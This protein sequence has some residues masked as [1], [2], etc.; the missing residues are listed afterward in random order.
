MR[1]LFKKI[2][3]TLDGLLHGVEQGDIGL[4]DIQRPFVWSPTRVRDLFDSMFKGFPVG[5]LL[6][7]AN[8][9][10]VGT[11][12]IGADG[13]QRKVPR[14]LIVDGQQRL[15]SL[16]AV[17]RGKVVLNSDFEEQRITL[18]FRPRDGKFEVA[19][20]AVTRDPEF[21]A[22]LSSIW[23]TEGG[24]YKVITDFLA[25]LA[26]TRAHSDEEKSEIAENINRA[27]ALGA[28]PFTALEI[29]SS[30]SEEQVAD[31]FVRIN[32]EG[33]KLNE[34][35]FILTLLSVFWDQGRFDLEWFART[36]KK[37]STG[38]SP[39]NHHI[40]PDPDQLLRTA[41][42]VGFGRGRLNSVYQV[43]RGKNADTGLFSEA[44]RDRQF[45]RLQ[46]AQSAVLDL[47]NWHEFLKCL[48]TAGFRSGQMISSQTA[49]LYTYAF[50]LIGRRDFK[51]DPFRL[52]TLIARWFFMSSLTGRYT[53]SPETVM[54]QDLARLRGVTDPEQFEQIL[55]DNIATQLHRDFW[56][57]GVPQILA[58]S[59]GRGP[60]LFAYYASLNILN[61]PVLFSKLRV[62][63]LSDPILRGTRLALER[64][65]LFPVAYLKKIGHGEI[66]DYNQIAN[67][68]LLEWGDNGAITDRAPADY[69]PEYA[70]RFAPH[71]LAEM[72][73]L[74]ALPD[75][76][77]DMAYP[78]FLDA[79]RKLMARV[80]HEGYDRLSGAS[81]P[82]KE[83]PSIA[84]LLTSEEDSTIE[85]KASARYNLHT[86]QR[87]ERIEHAIA[88]T[89]AGFAN[90]KGGTLLIGVNDA[91]EPVGL[92]NDYSLVTKG[93]QDGFALWLT[94]FL[95]RIIGRPAAASLEL[96]F[97]RAGEHD[98]CRVDVPA[99]PRPVYVHP[100]G[101]KVDE[102]YVRIGNS[103][104]QLTTQEFA[105]YQR[106][107]WRA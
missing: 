54:D 73:R 34:A 2:D 81:A 105:E 100:A 25:R 87:D 29:D 69:F 15:T 82:V 64:H 19:D 51:I 68:A 10:L 59:A 26:N 79:R 86:G 35:D 48:T 11:K 30:V 66:R 97:E 49:I 91:K 41:I 4:P 78:D 77:A 47:T 8:D 18:A 101:A 80:I 43:L 40:Q 17:L 63:E 9:E 28:Y 98:I 3:Y 70:A 89:I 6:F 93:N 21:I 20:A 31:I 24:S 65:H 56:E 50:Y 106:D 5:Y 102:F 13:K 38:P 27:F 58:T 57:I 76:W 88:K 36:A 95:E 55:N 94:D 92:K 61:A 103:T 16:Y 72:L 104:R 83:K 23:S 96:G 14:L 75:G 37:P 7:W 33:V 53:N 44:E 71:D 74:H 42:A 39:Y 52:R 67:F 46:E 62:P 107:H 99:S 85:F 45:A 90:A 84:Q 32:S 12:Q 22:D 1:T 60:G